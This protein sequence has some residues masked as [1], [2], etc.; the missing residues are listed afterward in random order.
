MDKQRL[1]ENWMRFPANASTWVVA[2]IS[3]AI[4]YW[5]GLTPAEQAAL[6][7]AYPW[8]KTLAPAASFAAFMIARLWPQ[9]V[10]AGG[11]EAPTMTQEQAAKL[12]SVLGAA[13]K[14]IEK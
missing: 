3:Y 6:L 13:A 14:A 12:L 4:S 2:A 7:T 10:K 9:G 5:I 1:A 8:I 11:V